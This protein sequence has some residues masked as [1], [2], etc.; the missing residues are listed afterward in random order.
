[1]WKMEKKINKIKKVQFEGK[2]NPNLPFPRR[3]WHIHVYDDCSTYDVYCAISQ[4]IRL[5][6]NSEMNITYPHRTVINQMQTT[7]FMSKSQPIHP[8]TPTPPKKDS[9]V[10]TQL[11]LRK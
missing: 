9:T 2:T 6:S 8:L 1:M 3:H 11:F 10:N 4:N 7:P 5:D